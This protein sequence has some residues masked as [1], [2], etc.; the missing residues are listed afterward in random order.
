MAR[1][2]IELKIRSVTMPET[3]P[4]PEQIARIQF[5]MTQ[6]IVDAILRERRKENQKNSG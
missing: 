2:P 5:I 1:K 3:D 4:T 6:I